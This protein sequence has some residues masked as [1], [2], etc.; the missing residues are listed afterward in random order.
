M[1]RRSLVTPF[2]F[3]LMKLKHPPQQGYEVSLIPD[4]DVLRDFLAL[5]KKKLVLTVLT[6][7]PATLEGSA[8]QKSLTKG[9]DDLTTKLTA[10]L[11]HTALGDPA[12]VR[13]ALLEAAH[14]PKL[15]EKHKIFAL[16]TTVLFFNKNYVDRVVGVRPVEI[17]TKSRFLLRNNDMNIFSA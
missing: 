16:P 5:H 4:E 3:Q 15:M 13:I 10:V 2:V 12:H 6:A 17:M 14:A 11:H 8:R 1:F 9:E 7:A